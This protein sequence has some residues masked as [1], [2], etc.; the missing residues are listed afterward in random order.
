MNR[1]NILGN[2][3]DGFTQGPSVNKRERIYKDIPEEVVVVATVF[4][5]KKTII[6]SELS[7]F[8]QAKLK[9]TG[10]I[11][12]EINKD[13]VIEIQE[14]YIESNYRGKACIIVEGGY[15]PLET[16]KEYILYLS[17]LEETDE[18]GKIYYRIRKKLPLNNI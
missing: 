9:V 13:D 15:E 4:G 11:S 1:N 8:T 14:P 7:G 18:E 16:S 2:I 3:I 6:V 12:G 10:V 17:Q 5:D